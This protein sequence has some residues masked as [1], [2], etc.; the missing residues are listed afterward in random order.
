MKA[1]VCA[2]VITVT[3]YGAR[4]VATR[5]GARTPRRCR[6]GRHP[7]AFVFLRLLSIG[8]PR[9][10]PRRARQRVQEPHQGVWKGT[11]IVVNPRRP[12]RINTTQPRERGEAHEGCHLQLLP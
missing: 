5:R 6:S 7:T 4:S 10:P 1:A 12:S 8:W 2:T 11:P 3:A 9:T